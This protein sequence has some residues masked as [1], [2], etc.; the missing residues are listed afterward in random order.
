MEI[1]V[2]P[3]AGSEQEMRA[4]HQMNRAAWDESASSYTAEI[5]Q[6]IAFLRAGQSNIHPI[7]R[8]NLGDLAGWCQRAIHLQCASG[9]DTLSLWNL[10]VKEVIGVDISEKM[11]ANATRIS[12]ELGIPAT[13]YCCDVLDAPAALD[14]TADLVYTGRGALCW[15]HDIRQWA[16]VVARLL[17]RG[18]VLHVFDDH[19]F[20]LMF[21]PDAES[22][23]MPEDMNYFSRSEQVVG[24]PSSYIADD[25]LGVPPD[26]LQK[27]FVRLW[28]LADIFQALREAG[29]EIEHLGEHPDEYY[30]PFSNLAPRWRGRIP[31]TFSL[32][33]RR[34]SG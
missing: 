26:Q 30:D 12:A 16:R 22:F 9:K 11:I 8:K 19:P 7:E 6:T 3:V 5:D 18:G 10:G 1:K 24:W 20:S 15:I 25:S 23:V 28:P 33:A 32:L 27:Q 29:L 34:T 2:V 31:M 21:D 17:K 14:G 4:R 13:W